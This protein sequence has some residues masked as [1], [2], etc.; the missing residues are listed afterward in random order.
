M[1]YFTFSAVRATR[2]FRL[3]FVL[4]SFNLAA[5]GGGGGSSGGGNASNLPAFPVN[6]NSARNLVGGAS[7]DQTSEQIGARLNTLNRAANSLLV[8]DN[9]FFYNDGTTARAGT[10]CTGNSCTTSGGGVSVTLNREDFDFT[11]TTTNEYQPVMI[12]RGVSLAQ[13]RSRE[14]IGGEQVDNL[15]YGGWLDHSFFFVF[16]QE[17]STF[18]VG[19][20]LSAG[21]APGTNPA[22]TG[23]GTWTG[24]MVGGDVSATTSRGHGIQGDAEIDIDDF[25]NPDVDIRF[26]NIYDLDSGSTRGDMRWDNIAVSNG[27]FATGS[28]TNQIQGKFYGPNHEEVGGVFERNQIVGA[29]GAK[30]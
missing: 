11:S 12:D 29:F 25:N 28:G 4:A 27:A 18:S 30:R 13:G 3:A 8:G 16:V 10:T 24:V 2:L 22:A 9:H 23:G 20:G 15:G 5:C 21:D 14:R 26:T 19:Y 17:Q 7:F 6:S 1:S